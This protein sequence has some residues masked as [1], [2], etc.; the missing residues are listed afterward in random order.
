MCFINIEAFADIDGIIRSFFRKTIE[1]IAYI[2]AA[3]FFKLAWGREWSRGQINQTPS[4]L[5]VIEQAFPGETIY[6]N[7]RITCSDWLSRK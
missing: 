1:N 2:E 5:S 7:P 3:K 4:L 6:K